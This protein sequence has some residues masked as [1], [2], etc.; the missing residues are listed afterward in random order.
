M[1]IQSIEYE[2]SSY[3]YHVLQC[4]LVMCF[5]LCHA[6]LCNFAALHSDNSF[7]I[8]VDQDLVNSGN[9]LEDMRSLSLLSA[10]SLVISMV[11]D[12]VDFLIF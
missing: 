7:E 2:I 3:V 11:L 10:C 6:G 4:R 8:F 9:L 5:G 12:L 1:C